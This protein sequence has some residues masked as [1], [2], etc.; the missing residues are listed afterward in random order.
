MSNAFVWDRL[1]EKLAIVCSLSLATG[2]AL[3]QHRQCHAHYF[4]LRLQENFKGEKAL[5][6]SG[7]YLGHDRVLW[8]HLLGLYCL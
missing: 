7:S 4:R 2:H 3:W 6:F 5:N 8:V 1:K